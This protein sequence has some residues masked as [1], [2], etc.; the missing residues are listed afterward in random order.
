M[1]TIYV[2]WPWRLMQNLNKTLSVVLEMTRTLWNLTRAL[3][4]LHSIVC[5]KICTF[6]CS[7]CVKYSIFD[8]NEY[9]GVIFHDSEGW[10]K[11]WR[12]N[13]LRFGKWHEEYGKVSPEDLKVSKLE[14]WRDS[15]KII[16]LKFTE[17]LCVWTMK[18]DAKFEKELTCRFKIGMSNLMNFDWRTWKSQTF[19]F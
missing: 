13:D 2:S 9:R 4:S 12:K 5:T 8:L 19:S 16:S 11:L 14:L 18:N 15:G 17:E 3:E 10:C 7:Y 1:Q 6:I